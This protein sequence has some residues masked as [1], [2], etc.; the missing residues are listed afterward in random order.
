MKIYPLVTIQ[1]S[2]LEYTY[3][4]LNCRLTL[5]FYMNTFLYRL[6]QHGIM[7]AQVV[8][9]NLVFKTFEITSGFQADQKFSVSKYVSSES[10]LCQELQKKLILRTIKTSAGAACVIFTKKKTQIE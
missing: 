2:P 10:N 9:S 7:Q 8:Y 4:I 5:A 6:K 1:K 3:F